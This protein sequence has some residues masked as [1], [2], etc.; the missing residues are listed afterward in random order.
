[1][2][3]GLKHPRWFWSGLGPGLDPGP[4]PG[5]VHGEL[6]VKKMHFISLLNRLKRPSA[7][8][9]S[10]SHVW[11]QNKSDGGE[12]GSGCLLLNSFTG[13]L[14]TVNVLFFGVLAKACVSRDQKD[15]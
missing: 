3:P 9:R 13:F 8:S 1:M 15:R 4:G 7:C 10:R 11:I 2:A 5:L 14:F 6:L 12:S